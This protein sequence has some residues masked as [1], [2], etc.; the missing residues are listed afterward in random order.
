MISIT[1]DGRLCLLTWMKEVGIILFSFYYC[2]QK[3]KAKGSRETGFQDVCVC[4]CVCVCVGG[5]VGGWVCG[6]GGGG[7]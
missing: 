6:C 4:V 7:E 2:F 1:A 3:R 5:W